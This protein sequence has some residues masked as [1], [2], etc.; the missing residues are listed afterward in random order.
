[1][2]DEK[3]LKNEQ[4]N[5][6]NENDNLEMNNEIKVLKEKLANQKD[7]I[8]EKD[9]RIKRLMAE[10]ENFKKRSDKERTNLYN[11]VMGDVVTSL[12][13]VLDNLEKDI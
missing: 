5:G 3:N 7:E 8:E 4:V 13:P 10:F 1:M 12:L 9:D 11:S 6:N 2:E